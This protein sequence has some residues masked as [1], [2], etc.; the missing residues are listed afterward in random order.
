MRRYKTQDAR[1]KQYSKINFQIPIWLLVLVCYLS[2]VTCSF[3]LVSGSELV[4]NAHKYDKK[5]IEFQG[6]VIGDI[7]DRGDHVWMNVNDGTRA[8]GIW[9]KKE[10]VSDIAVMGDYTH[11]GDQVKVTGTFYRADPQ[12]GGDLDIRAS[13]I[14]VLKTGY[15]VE[16]PINRVKVIFA[17]VLFVLVLGL[18]LYF[19]AKKRLGPKS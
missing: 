8:I 3:A 2:L 13:K 1:Y 6:E 14:E 7:M 10:M 15:K 5:V 4:E 17:I 16:H 19:V 12:H 11:I 9:A 18:H